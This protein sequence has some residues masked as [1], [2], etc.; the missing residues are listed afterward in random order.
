MPSNTLLSRY[1]IC[2]TF[3]NTSSE[4]E[5]SSFH[6]TLSLESVAPSLSVHPMPP[7]SVRHRR[8]PPPTPTP[9]LATA[10]SVRR[11]PPRPLYRR[12]RS[13]SAALSARA[14]VRRRPSAAHAPGPATALLPEHTRQ[15]MAEED[16]DAGRRTD[17]NAA[18][19]GKC[20]RLTTTMA[21]TD[22]RRRG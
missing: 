2:A 22:R 10:S 16:N 21:A 15:A 4:H 3:K 1:A 9:M 6:A 12:R 20:G 13:P 19:M 7:S 11:Q 8:R 14:R 17:D 18:D 5:F